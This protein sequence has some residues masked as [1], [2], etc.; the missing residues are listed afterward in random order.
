MIALSLSLSL[1]LS[2]HFV[3]FTRISVA[4]FWHRFR[5]SRE[6]GY[7]RRVQAT[8][9]P[10]RSRGGAEE[11]GRRFAFQRSRETQREPIEA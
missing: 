7:A 6:I 11:G 9:L 5:R 8:A 10:P 1:S 3:R 4:I 2:L